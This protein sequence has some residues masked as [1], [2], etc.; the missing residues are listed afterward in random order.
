MLGVHG[1]RVPATETSEV[2]LCRRQ[3]LIGTRARNGFEELPQEERSRV[4]EIRQQAVKISRPT[5]WEATNNQRRADRA[6]FELRVPLPG[7][8]EPEAK[9]QGIDDVPAKDH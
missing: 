6:P 4:V 9:H 1:G 2:A 5:A 7:L 3:P 8:F